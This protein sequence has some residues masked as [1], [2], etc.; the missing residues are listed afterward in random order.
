MSRHI[1]PGSLSAPPPGSGAARPADFVAR[2]GADPRNTTKH[3]VVPTTALL[4][5][6]T[7]DHTA[8]A[9]A[10]SGSATDPAAPSC[11]STRDASPSIGTV[12]VI[13]LG[14]I[15]GSVARD[16]VANGI[17]VIGHDR[18]QDTVAAAVGAGMIAGAL[19]DDLSGAEAAD[20]VILATPVDQSPALL[21]ALAALSTS[22][23]LIMDVGSTKRSMVD[24]A[25]ALGL[26]SLFV[27]AHPLAGDHRWGWAASRSNLFQGARVYLCPTHCSDADAVA[28]ARSFWEMLGAVTVLLDATRHDALLACSSHLPQLTATALALTL[29]EHGVKR[30]QLGSGGRD[31]TRLAGSS[32]VLWTAITRDNA[33]ELEAAL[34]SLMGKLG[35][36]RTALRGGDRDQLL[37]RFQAGWEWFTEAATG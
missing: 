2:T 26:A 1:T 5:G 32:P 30:M 27:G 10:A 13:G 28:L 8:R 6:A 23:R 18:D 33:G 29:A 12:V 35:E 17:R 34:D 37:A 9:S 19:S 20:V 21:V 31:M 11:T 25:T 7:N 22:A 14:L 16:L 3:G 36:M 4:D 15:G 24:A